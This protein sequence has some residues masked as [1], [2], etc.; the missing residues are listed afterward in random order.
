MYKYL[1]QVPYNTIGLLDVVWTPLAGPNDEDAGKDVR[2]IDSDDD[3]LNHPWHYRLDIKRACDL[4]VFCEMAYIQYTFFG[5]QF[6]SE[7][8]QQTTFSPVFEYS[9]IHSV[10]NATP[11]FLEFLKGSL[12]IS[13]H[14]TQHIDTP[15]DRIG[16]LN[17]IVRESIRTNEPLG[18]FVMA[19]LLT[20][21]KSFSSFMRLRIIN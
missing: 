2:D 17:D 4:P 21:I 11:E 18:Y 5:E 13:V 10:N 16:T 19:F 1:F 14:V 12:E 8:V 9:K 15:N 3:F 7:A 6:T 20:F